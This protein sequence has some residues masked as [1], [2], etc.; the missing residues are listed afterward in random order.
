MGQRG[1]KPKRPALKILAGNPGHR[2][3]EAR[4]PRCIRRGIPD[5]PPELTGEAA[6]EWDRLASE[7][8]DLATVDRG[9]LA[10]YC[11]A[12]ADLLAARAA[13]LESERFLKVPIQTSKGQSLG[14]RLVEHPAVKLLADASRR[15]ERLGAALGLNPAARSRLEGEAPAEASEANKVL[16]IRDRIQAARNG[17]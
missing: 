15:I 12:V 3:V 4:R 11:L 10:A 1:P 6:A 9:I 8:P 14:F 17:G 5:R 16:A 13:I 2:P 7:L